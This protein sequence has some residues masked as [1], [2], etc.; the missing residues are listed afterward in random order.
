[1]RIPTL[2]NNQDLRLQTH[3]HTF[4][5]DTASLPMS[6]HLSVHFDGLQGGPDDSG[7]EDLCV[8]VSFVDVS[9]EQ[10]AR[11]RFASIHQL[12]KRGLL[13]NWAS[14]VRGSRKLRGVSPGSATGS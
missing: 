2:S 11:D 13:G 9:F 12:P 1:M 6:L 5:C 7:L 3:S 10:L 14:G 8:D 4:E